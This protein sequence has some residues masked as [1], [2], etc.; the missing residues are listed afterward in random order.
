MFNMSYLFWL[1]ISLKI[2][3][4][5][6]AVNRFQAKPVDRPLKPRSTD[7]AW[8]EIFYFFS[9]TGRPTIVP[10]DRCR[11]AE[12]SGCFGRPD[13][14]TDRRFS[15]LICYIFSFFSLSLSLTSLSEPETLLFPQNFFLSK[16]LTNLKSIKNPSQF[17]HSTSR[18]SI[19]GSSNHQIRR[20]SRFSV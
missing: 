4:G 6:D 2:F 8:E 5:P 17:P 10:V 3:F 14:S 18:S 15:A 9:V 7:S 12:L 19:S 13:R 16:L 20:I 11:P 1:Q